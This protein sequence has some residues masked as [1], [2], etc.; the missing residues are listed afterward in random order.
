[1]DL[2][3]K[4]D[5][6]LHGHRK[7]RRLLRSHP[8]KQ[9]DASAHGLWLLA[10][11]WARGS[12][13]DGFV[14]EDELERWDDDWEHLAKR[15]VAAEMWEPVTKDGEPGYLFH[16]WP[17]YN[18]T[19]AEIAALS[20]KRAEAGRLG[21]M[22]SGESRRTKQNSRKPKQ[23]GEANGGSRRSK[24]EAKEPDST[25]GEALASSNSEASASKQT[26]S[27]TNPIAVHSSTGHASAGLVSQVQVVGPGGKVSNRRLDE[28]TYDRVMALTGGKYDYA[29]RTA[30]FILDRAPGDVRSPGAYVVA[31][32]ND[33]PDAFRYRRGS[34]KKADQCP[35]HAGE[36]ADTC[37]AC[38]IDAKLGDLDQ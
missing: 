3:F 15:L 8:E 22:R 10:G 23:T 12:K 21:G 25:L 35:E 20:N 29:V 4:V 28:K 16:D 33:D 34:P 27:K 13:T 9:R 17:E 18:P 11:S 26:R 31:A 32:I 37:R 36:W 7:T 5:G 14:P 38:A 24:S 1:M 30:A 19:E 6:L 2:W